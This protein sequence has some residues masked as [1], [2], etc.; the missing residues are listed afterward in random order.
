MEMQFNALLCNHRLINGNAIQCF[1]IIAMY[2]EF[3]W[4]ERWKIEREERMTKPKEEHERSKGRERD[5]KTTGVP[6]Y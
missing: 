3:W 6:I 5:E 1:I 2:Y 4:I